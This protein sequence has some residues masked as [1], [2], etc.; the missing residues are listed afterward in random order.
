MQYH[1]AH[2]N[3]F[4]FLLRCQNI[5]FWIFGQFLVL[6]CSFEKKLLVRISLYDYQTLADSVAK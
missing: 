2:K 5:N 6:F 4:D 1:V 3:L